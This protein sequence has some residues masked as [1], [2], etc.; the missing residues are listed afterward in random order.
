MTRFFLIV[1]FVCPFILCKDPVFALIDKSALYNSTQFLT[2]EEQKKLPLLIALSLKET[3]HKNPHFDSFIEGL[4]AAEQENLNDYQ[5]KPEIKAYA[6]YAM[7]ID[8]DPLIKKQLNESMQYLRKKQAREDVTPIINDRIYYKIIKS[9]IYEGIKNSKTNK[10]KFNFSIKDINE[11]ILT[12]NYSLSGPI[13]CELS[14][15]IPGMAHGMIGM[16]LNEVREIYIH[17]EFAYG[18]FSNFGNGKAISVTVELVECES[19]DKT[20]YPV[21][22]CV[23]LSRDLK[24][25]PNEI[26]M[27]SLQKENMSF[28][29]KASWSFYKNNLP[30]LHLNDVLIYLKS[31]KNGSFES[32]ADCDKEILYKLYWLI[33]TGT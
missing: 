11:N 23:D 20:F 24:N 32:L 13:Q 16:R 28:C 5:K 18:V 2:K 6:E 22:T 30:Q 21:L 3:F 14:E 8:V 1:L 17:P 25:Y 26:D 7:Q 19:T 9:G 4:I 10:V 27:T 29:G 15:L 12:G 33:Y 31:E